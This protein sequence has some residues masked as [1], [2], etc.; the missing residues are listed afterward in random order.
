MREWNTEWYYRS[1]SVF[2]SMLCSKDEFTTFPALCKQRVQ[3]SKNSV[4]FVYFFPKKQVT[5]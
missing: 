3:T 5:S 1:R 2:F 4:D